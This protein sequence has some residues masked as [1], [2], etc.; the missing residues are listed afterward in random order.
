M[1]EKAT[2]VRADDGFSHISTIRA[3]SIMPAVKFFP[4]L[5]LALLCIG[6]ES[7][8]PQQKPQP[9]PVAPPA[10]SRFVVYSSAGETFLVDSD[11]GKVWRYDA[12]GKAFL[13]IPVTS[14]IAKYDSKG[15]LVQP[16]AKDP[17]GI[18]NTPQPK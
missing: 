5:V 14:K 4:A 16:D 11:A 1:L 12:N 10:H 7:I 3:C 9:A 15:N 2:V 8:Q 17:L 13:E 18:L 6:C